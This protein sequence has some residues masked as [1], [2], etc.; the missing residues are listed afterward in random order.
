MAGKGRVTVKGT[1]IT[2]KKNV[3][4]REGQR[5]KIEHIRELRIYWGKLTERQFERK[6]GQSARAIDSQGRKQG[7]KG[8][9]FRPKGQ[10]V[11][12]TP[13][14]KKPAKKSPEFGTESCTVN[15]AVGSSLV[16]FC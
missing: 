4:I 16:P 14:A 10:P 6:L 1:K 8:S 11:K 7:R 13:A 5:W 9:A 2:K 12:K 15:H 3:H